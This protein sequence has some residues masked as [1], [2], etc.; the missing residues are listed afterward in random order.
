MRALTPQEIVRVWD[1]GSA[2]HA[3]D[4]DGATIEFRLPDSRDL[5]LAAR[6]ADAEAAAGV[7]LARCV[8][9]GD[10]SA[11]AA[12]EALAQRMLEVDP[13]AETLVDLTCPSCAH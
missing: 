9:R 5:A 1:A 13:Q 7:L 2:M 8:L 6:A 11:A 10:M 3:L 4:P 12:R